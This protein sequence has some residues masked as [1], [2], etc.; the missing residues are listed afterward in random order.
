MHILKEHFFLILIQISLKFVPKNAAD[1]KLTL[2]QV[3]AWYP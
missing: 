2:G 3:M 1:N